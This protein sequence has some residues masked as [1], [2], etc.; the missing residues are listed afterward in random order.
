MLLTILAFLV[1]CAV[2]LTLY[3]VCLSLNSA[4]LRQ[5]LKYLVIGLIAATISITTLVTITVLF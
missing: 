4:Q 3:N 5:L 1:G 2:F